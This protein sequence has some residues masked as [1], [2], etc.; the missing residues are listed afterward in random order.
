M[1]VGVYLPCNPDG[2]VVGIDRKSGKPLQ[3]HA[4]APFMATFRIKRNRSD[5]EGTENLLEKANVTANADLSRSGTGMDEPTYEVWQS[6]MFKVGDDCRQDVLA[7]QMIA[8][9]RGIW[10]HVGLDVFVYPYRVTPTAPGCGVIDPGPPSSS[11]AFAVSAACAPGCR[12]SARA[13]TARV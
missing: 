1:E 11:S 8:A 4:K 3:S 7:L 6:A 13:H 5:M 2:V 9:F 12:A 10:N